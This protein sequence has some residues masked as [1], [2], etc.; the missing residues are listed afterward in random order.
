MRALYI[1]KLRSAIGL[2]IFF[3][4]ILGSLIA[5]ADVIAERKANFK[6]NAAAM[7]A[8]NAALGG[9]NFDAAITQATTIAD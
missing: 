9:G 3:V 6:A 8:I 5:K 4:L 1:L 7:R 2:T